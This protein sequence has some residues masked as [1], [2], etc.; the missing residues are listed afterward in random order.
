M[1][2]EILLVTSR[3]NRGA[4]P[5][6][7]LRM[8]ESM[9]GVEE[10][11]TQLTLKPRRYKRFEAAGRSARRTI[12]MTGRAAAPEPCQRHEFRAP[13]R[14]TVPTQTCPCVIEPL[15]IWLFRLT[16]LRGPV[17]Q[18]DGAGSNGIPSLGGEDGGRDPPNTVLG[19]SKQDNVIPRTS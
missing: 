17:K 8:C 15:V 12:A 10:R 5:S 19:T 2:H 18:C 1:L 7:R 9:S 3:S 14:I 11:E 13:L 4:E 6:D 16:F